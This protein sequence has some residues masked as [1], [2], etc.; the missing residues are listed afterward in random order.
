MYI[1]AQHDEC[2]LSTDLYALV[3]GARGHSAAVE[4]V[5]DVVDQVLMV[6]ID[7][8]GLEHAGRLATFHSDLQII[9]KLQRALSWRVLRKRQST[10]YVNLTL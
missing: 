5:A 4:V 3:A 6:R 9:C 1:H 2:W 8:F 7:G 10:E